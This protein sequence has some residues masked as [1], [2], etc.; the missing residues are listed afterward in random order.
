MPF[1]GLWDSTYVERSRVSQMDLSTH[2]Y[3]QFTEVPFLI[4]NYS[5]GGESLKILIAFVLKRLIL[6]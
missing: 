3:L 1:F 5:W 4:K 6:K 2:I